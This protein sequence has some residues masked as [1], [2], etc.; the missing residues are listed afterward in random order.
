MMQLLVVFV[1]GRKAVVKVPRAASVDMLLAQVTKKFS[2]RSQRFV[3]AAGKELQRK[4]LLSDYH[5]Q[6]GSLLIESPDLRGGMHK[7]GDTG[8]GAGAG[9]TGVGAGVDAGSAHAGQQDD[10]NY[11]FQAALMA[12][13]Q[14]PETV[15]TQ[16]PIA[17]KQ[18][19][20]KHE[21][22]GEGNVHDS[23]RRGVAADGEVLFNRTYVHN[24]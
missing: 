11:S 13:L 1:N 24:R 2:S 3:T 15:S 5:L 18:A 8:D 20:S 7:S 9:F 4:R 6:S 22:E 23:K 16:P 17:V 21:Y 19:G 10:N 14:Q 12:S